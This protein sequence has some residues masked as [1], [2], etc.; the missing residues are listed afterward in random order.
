MLL[1]F[2]CWNGTLPLEKLYRSMFHL[3]NVGVGWGLWCLAK[4][5]LSEHVE[6]YFAP[7]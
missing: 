1:I 7:R 5:T 6:R 4:E 3:L 2:G